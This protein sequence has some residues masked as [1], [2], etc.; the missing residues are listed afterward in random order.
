MNGTVNRPMNRLMNRPMKMTAQGGAVWAIARCTVL[1]AWR[2]RYGWIVVLG[3]LGAVA[4]AE[5]L[6][7]AAVTESLEIRQAVLAALLRLIAVLATGLFMTTA[8]ARECHDK[9]LELVFSLPLPRG[10]YYLGKL[11]GHALLCLM[12]A[13]LAAV[14][15]AWYAPPAQVL[16]WSLSLWC[17]LLIVAA[18]CLF[19]TLSFVQA[20]P[21]FAAAMAFY[22]LGRS[23]TA[24]ELMA[25]GP[26]VDP[27]AWSQQ[28]V[29]GL[30]HFLGLLLPD[31]D[32]FARS[33][34]LVY[35]VDGWADL[36]L[37]AV[38]T[39]LYV[40]LL[41]AMALFDLYRKNI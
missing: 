31:L 35:G 23:I 41:S 14:L 20:A 24:M 40:C 29:S 10:G 28:I 21:A 2:G 30:V 37:L 25:G 5:F 17:E 36:P 11:A 7:Q 16:A 27:H 13:S 18:L 1:E 38:Q 9:G 19:L 34:W 26:L 33:D 15:L 22:V 8:L 12:T 39:L 3:A 4:V 32:R 6:G